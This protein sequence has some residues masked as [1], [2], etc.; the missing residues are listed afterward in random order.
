[1]KRLFLGLL[2]GML[3]GAVGFG[4]AVPRP[5]PDL[6]MNDVTGTQ[7]TLS[8][9]RGDV[10]VVAFMITTCAHCQAVSR[11]LEQLYSE[12]KDRGLRVIGCMFNSEG[13]PLEFSLKQRLLYPVGSVPRPAVEQFLG[14]PGGVRVGTPQLAFIDRKGVI[15]AQSAIQGSPLL[16]TPE[17]LRSLVTALLKGPR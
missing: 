13:D 5:A 8:H 4:Q 14:I 12:M 16:Q 17:V 15:R 9:Y 6:T 7:V 1:M 2:S 10:V 11:E 3:L